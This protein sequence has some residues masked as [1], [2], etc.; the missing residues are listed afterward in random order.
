MTHQKPKTGEVWE[1]KGGV[2]IEHMFGD[3]ITCR[4]DHDKLIV[5]DVAPIELGTIFV[6]YITCTGNKYHM[7][8]A[9][10]MAMYKRS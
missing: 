10:F 4:E 2:W 6:T 3:F 8:L 9:K 1:R 7:S 5:D